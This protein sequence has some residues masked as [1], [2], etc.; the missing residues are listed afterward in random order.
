VIDRRVRNGYYQGRS[1]DVMMVHE[2][3]W[4]A[5]GS[6]ANH[7]S[8]FSYDTHVPV[9]FLGPGRIKPGQYHGDVAIQDIAPTLSQILGIAA[10]SGSVGRVLGEMLP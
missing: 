3:N 1:A 5:G 6:T 2:P 4:Q 8:P 10:P 7:G 9:I